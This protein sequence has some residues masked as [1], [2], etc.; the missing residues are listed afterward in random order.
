MCERAER[1]LHA[2]TPAEVTLRVA[3]NGPLART[4]RSDVACKFMPRKLRLSLDKG[5]PVLDGELDEGFNLS[6][7]FWQFEDVPGVGRVL[8]VVMEKLLTSGSWEY[9]LETDITAVDAEVTEQVFLDMA[10][11]GAPEGRLTI[12]LFGKVCVLC[13]HCA[14]SSYALR[15]RWRRARWPTLRHCALAK[16]AW[17]S[18]GKRSTTRVHCFTASSL[19]SWRRLAISPTA[20]ELVARASTASVS[21]TRASSSSIRC[22]IH[23]MWTSWQGCSRAFAARAGSL[24]PV[25]GKCRPQHQWLAGSAHC[26][27]PRLC[28]SADL[29]HATPTVLHHDH[30]HASLGRQTRRVWQGSVGAKACETNRAGWQRQREAGGRGPD[31]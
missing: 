5:E 13:L 8:T 25:H 30:A 7:S 23:M 11:D 12:G 18:R 19:A 27:V 2:Q 9:L 1:T 31:H 26:L 3:L 22:V 29:L 20:M 4:A 28:M 14:G 21:M 10:I 6:G 17:A 15:R 24:P 16:R